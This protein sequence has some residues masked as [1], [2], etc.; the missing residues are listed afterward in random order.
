M[1]SQE[2]PACCGTRS[3]DARF[4]MCYGGIVVSRSG[5]RRACCGTVDTM[6]QGSEGVAVET[7]L[8]G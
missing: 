1:V 3:Y 7:W 2:S 4:R 8:A 6:M 5:I